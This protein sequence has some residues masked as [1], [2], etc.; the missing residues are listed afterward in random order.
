MFP[1]IGDFLTLKKAHS[2]SK[3]HKP[4]RARNEALRCEH[5]FAEIA[6]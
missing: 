1:V 5:H 4:L 6:R 3:H 2:W